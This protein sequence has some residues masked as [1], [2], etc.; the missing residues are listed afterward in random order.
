MISFED[1]CSGWIDICFQLEK[2]GLS[3]YRKG[4]IKGSA[5]EKYF[6]ENVLSSFVAKGLECL[7]QMY[8]EGI[9][10]KFDFL[11]VNRRVSEFCVVKAAD[12]V[13]AFEVK[14]HGFYSYEAI[15]HVKSVLDS[16]RQVRHGAELFYVTFRETN[17]YDRKVREI[18]GNLAQLYYRLADSGDGVQLPPK[19]YFPKEW[20]RLVRNLSAL[21]Q[22]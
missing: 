20:D 10:Y 9:N 11:L 19:C 3:K 15:G 12:V 1:F 18:F 14:A 2:R 7:S 21:K 17:T 22:P 4:M 6:L 5:F 8:I 13:A 16:V